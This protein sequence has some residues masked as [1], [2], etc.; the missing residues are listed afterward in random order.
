MSRVH[1]VEDT[2][3]GQSPDDHLAPPLDIVGML[4]QEDINKLFSGCVSTRRGTWSRSEDDLLRRVLTYSH[5]QTWEW[6]GKHLLGRNGK[7]CRERWVNYLDPALARTQMGKEEKTALARIIRTHGRAWTQV[8]KRLNM[9]RSLHSLR[10][11]RG[12]NEVKN[13]SNTAQFEHILS[14]SSSG[15]STDMSDVTEA[16]CRH[17]DKSVHTERGSITWSVVSKMRA[18]H[19]VGKTTVF[20]LHPRASNDYIRLNR[21]LNTPTKKGSRNAHHSLLSKTP[22]GGLELMEPIWREACGQTQINS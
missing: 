14:A 19:P 22:I 13:M 21:V 3:S 2:A 15:Y 1:A 16:G 17:Y 7:Q 9:W 8:T 5:G 12:P 18:P 4:S 10:G 20:M 11:A 6:V